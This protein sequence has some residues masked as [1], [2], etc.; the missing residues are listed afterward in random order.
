MNLKLSGDWKR[1]D[2]CSRLCCRQY[3]PTVGGGISAQSSADGGN[4]ED[5]P[6]GKEMI[7]YPLQN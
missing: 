3:S 1:N 4:E 6:A 2:L 5:E 7:F